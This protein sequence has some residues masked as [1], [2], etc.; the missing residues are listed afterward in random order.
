MDT[1]RRLTFQH[2][3]LL[4]AIFAGLA[5][6]TA[7]SALQESPDGVRVV[8]ARHDLASGHVI[9]ESDLRV[10]T[11]TSAPDHALRT[12]QAVGRRVAGPMR[13]GEPLTDHRVLQAD[14]L[15]GYGDDAVLTSVT[16]PDVSSLAGVRVGDRVDVIAVD[17]QGESRAEVVARD[18]E[19]VTAPPQDERDAVALGLVTTEE[20]A[21]DLASAALESR[22]TIMQSA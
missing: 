7:L 13:T 1:L 12:A 6:L 22:F 4:A 11:L 19:V 21:L 14:A 8:V 18:V 15:D 10:V 5:V 17:P 16:V 2:H 3:R 9:E 20:V